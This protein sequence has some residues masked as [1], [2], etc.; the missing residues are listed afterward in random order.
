[1]SEFSAHKYILENTMKSSSSHFDERLI[2]FCY[3]NI[4]CLLSMLF[5]ESLVVHVLLQDLLPY[6]QQYVLDIDGK[7]SEAPN[8]AHL[9]D[10]QICRTHLGQT[11]QIRVLRKFDFIWSL[12]GEALLLIVFWP[13]SLKYLRCTGFVFLQ[14]I[15]TRWYVKYHFTCIRTCWKMVWVRF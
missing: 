11:M 4:C 2:F 9:A 6:V 12:R 10:I 3:I 1:M 15:S 5:F 14:R 7:T 13:L 8:M